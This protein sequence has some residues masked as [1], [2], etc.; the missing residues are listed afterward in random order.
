MRT[1]ATCSV[2]AIAV[3]EGAKSLVVDP[4][5]RDLERAQS[6]HVLAFTAQDELVLVESEGDF[7]MQEWD[8]VCEA[9]KKTCC[10]SEKKAGGI[11]MITDDNE[12]G[13]GPDLR[14]FVRSTLEEKVAADL[15]W[16]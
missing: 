13:S 7:S 1:T 12:D 14:H 3:N 2:V 11:D 9:A 8:D 10:Q 15:H 4:S 6:A 16:K 5:P